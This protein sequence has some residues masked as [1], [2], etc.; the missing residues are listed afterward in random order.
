MKI[1]FNGEAVEITEQM[2]TPSY[3][4][5]NEYADMRYGKQYSELD[6]DE[7]YQ[8]KAEMEQDEQDESDDHM[9]FERD[10]G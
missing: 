4:I 7:Q 8:I 3:G 6:A 5:H 1:V 9:L 2:L 10:R